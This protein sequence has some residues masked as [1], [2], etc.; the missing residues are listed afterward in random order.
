MIVDAKDHEIAQFVNRLTQ[1]AQEFGQTQQL[2]ERISQEVLATLRPPAPVP[3]SYY[4]LD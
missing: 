4:F 1:I 3:P 2:R